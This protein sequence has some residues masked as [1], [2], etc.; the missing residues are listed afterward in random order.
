MEKP[1]AIDKITF[2]SLDEHAV[3]E[4]PFGQ[5]FDTLLIG[6]SGR[7]ELTID[8]RPV[9]LTEPFVAYVHRGTL[10]LPKILSNKG[11]SSVWVIRFWPD[12]LLPENPMQLNAFLQE[13]VGTEIRDHDLFGRMDSIAGLIYQE[14]NARQTSMPVVRNLMGALIA[15]MESLQN[16]TA[17]GGDVPISSQ[18]T[19]FRNL[20]LLLEENFRRPVGV[21]F[22]ADSL[23]MTS[24]NLNII[25]QNVANLSVSEI[26]EERRMLESKKLLA[27]TDKSIS[28]IG[29]EVGYNEKACFTSVFKKKHGQT[30]SSFR[31]D[32]Q[33]LIS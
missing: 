24:R 4:V 15:M 33:K 28:E 26:I 31:K 5:A 14:V 22:Y 12:L 23:S 1:I 6:A 9:S 32:F 27:S 8:F 2:P 19:A 17:N 20:L 29:Y 10:P 7:L 25:C 30:P 21:E 13:S 18:R 11:V 16:E 3:F